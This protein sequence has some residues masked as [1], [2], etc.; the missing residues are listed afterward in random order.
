MALNWDLVLAF[1]PDYT[2]QG[3]VSMVIYPDKTTPEQVAISTLVRQACRHSTLDQKALRMPR[4][5]FPGNAIW[6]LCPLP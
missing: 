3:L 6:C 4:S 1:Y 2:S 5:L